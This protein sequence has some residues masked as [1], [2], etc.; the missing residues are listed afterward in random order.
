MTSLLAKRAAYTS[1]AAL[2]IWGLYQ[3]TSSLAP[4]KSKTMLLPFRATFAVP[5]AC[6]SCIS[7]VSKALSTLPGQQVNHQHPPLIVL[8]YANP[9]TRRSFNGIFSRFPAC[10]HYW[11]SATFRHNQQHSIHRSAGRSA[12]LRRSEWCSSKRCSFFVFIPPRLLE[13]MGQST[14]GRRRCS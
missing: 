9:Q 14:P 3:G 8:L 12:G 1:F 2:S 11:H 5:L 13:L 7:E 6:D 4:S 10:Y